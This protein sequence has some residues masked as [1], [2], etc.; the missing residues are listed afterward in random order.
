MYSQEL[1]NY[2][3]L[4]LLSGMTEEEIREK[5]ADRSEGED[6]EEIIKCAKKRFEENQQ[7]SMP[8]KEAFDNYEMRVKDELEFAESNGYQAYQANK[9]IISYVEALVNDYNA[10]AREWSYTPIALSPVLKDD[11]VY[12]AKFTEEEIFDPDADEENIETWDE[13]ISHSGFDFDKYVKQNRKAYMQGRYDSILAL[14]KPFKNTRLQKKQPPQPMQIP[15]VANGSLNISE[16]KV[17]K[18]TE[19]K[20][21]PKQKTNNAKRDRT[22]KKTQL[23]VPKSVVPNVCKLIDGYNRKA[24]KWGYDLLT[25]NADSN[26]ISGKF[27]PKNESSGF[28]SGMKEGY[29]N[30]DLGEEWN[31][32]LKLCGEK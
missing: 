30:G 27:T 1:E 2:T 4:C 20:I 16:P 29:R 25:F 14:L 19:K 15:T 23:T 17:R 28:M 32:I 5:L 31:K 7:N 10:R 24:A 18:K 8:K 21:E 13:L 11:G 22:A 6:V 26:T 9:D 3:F 12:Y